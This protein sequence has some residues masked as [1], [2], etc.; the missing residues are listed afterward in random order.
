MS[1]THVEELADNFKGHALCFRY[2]EVNKKPSDG[3]H[4]GIDAKDSCKTDGGEQ[5][6]ERVCDDNVTKPE[7]ER[8][9]G[10]A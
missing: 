10:D 2:L 4:N 8:T 7:C 1:G 3:A 9:Y 5:S 6:R